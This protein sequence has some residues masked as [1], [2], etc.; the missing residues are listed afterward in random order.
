MDT[1]FKDSLDKV[2]KTQKIDLKRLTKSLL[3]GLSA[4]AITY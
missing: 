4:F 1:V 3:R 2:N